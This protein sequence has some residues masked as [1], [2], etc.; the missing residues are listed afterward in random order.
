[1]NKPLDKES[2][3]RLEDMIDNHSLATVLDAIADICQQKADHLR[4][5]W[6]DDELAGSWDGAAS[7][8]E[9]A[10]RRANL[11]NI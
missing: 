11:L 6:Q 3:V 2:K 1:M 7:A 10:I 5:N 4:E 9:T 8:L